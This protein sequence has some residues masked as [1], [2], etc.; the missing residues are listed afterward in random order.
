MTVAHYALLI[1]AWLL[2][3]APFFLMKRNRAPAAQV[4]KRARWGVVTQS[5]AYCILW[6]WDFWSRPPAAWRTVLSIGCFAVAIVLIW[7]AIRAL[8][9]QWRIDAGLNPDHELVRSGPYR[10]VRHPIYASML[11]MLCGTGLLVAPLPILAVSIAVFLTGTEIRVR[12]EDS[13]LAARFGAG[14]RS[15]QAAVSAYIPYIR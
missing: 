4:D 7:T 2:W 9:R 5:V 3:M 10:G 11:C 13:L 14:F 15:Y 6:Q 12:V 1:G 8:G